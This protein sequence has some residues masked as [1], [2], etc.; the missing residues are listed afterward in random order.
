MVES[1]KKMKLLSELEHVLKR[2]QMY[3]SSTIETDETVHYL[4]ETDGETDEPKYMLHTKTKSINVGMYKLLWE[5]FDN[6]IDEIKRTK[7]KSKAK[8][9]KKHIIEV[10]LYEEDNKICV[11]DNG[12]GFYKAVEK[13]QKSRG[14]RG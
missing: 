2:P 14:A 6:S 5:I 10:T 3:V 1:K 12:E 4:E 11:R 7:G 9:K 13:H 8:F